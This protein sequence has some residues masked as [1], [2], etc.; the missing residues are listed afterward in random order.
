MLNIQFD[1]ILGI[2]ALWQGAYKLYLTVFLHIMYLV[3]KKSPSMYLKRTY[4]EYGT[5]QTH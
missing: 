5:L 2:T 4:L 1:L 3:A